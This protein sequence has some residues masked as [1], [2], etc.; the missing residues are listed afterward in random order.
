MLLS[1]TYPSVDYQPEQ[2]SPVTSHGTGGAFSLG[3]DY[4]LQAGHF[5]MNTGVGAAYLRSS[6][7][8]IDGRVELPNSI[9]QDGYDFTF[10]Y[11]FSGRNDAYSSLELQ[12]PLLFGASFPTSAGRVGG[13]VYF[14]LGGKFTF[15]PWLQSHTS[16]QVSSYGDYPQFLDP[17]TGMP[18]HQFFDA[19]PL[20]STITM[21]YSPSA[22]SALAV[23]N[24]VQNP[25]AL[26]TYNLLPIN[27]LASAEVGY[28]FAF[29]SKGSKEHLLRLALF[30]D[31]AL[32]NSFP[33]YTSLSPLNSSGSSRPLNPLPLIETPAVFNAEDMYSSL[34]VNPYLST[35]P[36]NSV[37]RNLT[38]GL[39]LVYAISLP[40]RHYRASGPCMCLT[41]D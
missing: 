15:T 13:S 22:P 23:P 30:A 27:V 24:S 28:S 8:V 14:L 26:T 35:L 29:A 10:V 9:D 3:F 7:P 4:R 5:L 34:R 6:F 2:V 37:L 32:L 36:Q 39:K 1:A 12:V 25:L 38:V 31:V 33:L 21:H 19:R 20:E 40:A 11:Q 16:L 18:E 17:F 41:D